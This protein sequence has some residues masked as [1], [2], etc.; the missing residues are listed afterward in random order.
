M[1]T[2]YLAARMDIDPRGAIVK[3]NSP[4]LEYL[5]NSFF[6]GFKGATPGHFQRS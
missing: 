4:P 2:V 6:I 1:F 3:V 5:P